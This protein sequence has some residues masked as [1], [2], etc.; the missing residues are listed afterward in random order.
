MRKSLKMTIGIGLIL[1]C[2]G[3]IL[4]GIGLS[5]GGI[6][7]LQVKDDQAL[8]KEVQLIP[9][10]SCDSCRPLAVKV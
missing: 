4:V 1:S 3:L 6:D 2:F 10:A 8:K 9:K 7:K 5:S